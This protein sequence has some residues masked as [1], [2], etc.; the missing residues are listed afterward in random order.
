MITYSGGVLDYLRLI[1][2][3]VFSPPMAD[4]KRLTPIDTYKKAEKW[5][6]NIFESGVILMDDD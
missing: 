4:N 1:I 5:P 6:E 2:A 3:R